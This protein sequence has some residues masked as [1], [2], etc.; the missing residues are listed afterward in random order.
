MPY[1]TLKKDLAARSGGEG[2]RAE[3]LDARN[4]L[5][6]NQATAVLIHDASPPDTA[7]ELFVALDKKTGVYFLTSVTD[8]AADAL[9]DL[10]VED[11]DGNPI[12]GTTDGT[13]VIY[14]AD[15]ATAFGAVQVR[16][17]NGFLVA[18]FSTINGGANALVYTMGGRALPIPHVPG[19]GGG[20]DIEFDD[21][22]AAFSKLVQAMAGLVDVTVRTSEDRAGRFSLI[23]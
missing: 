5:L 3:L 10:Q 20:D 18:D 15:P 7:I 22:G 13:W 11:E 21:A 19:A 6:T 8:G 23:P 16:H 17:L 12:V 2:L 1:A 4:R 9:L 14:D